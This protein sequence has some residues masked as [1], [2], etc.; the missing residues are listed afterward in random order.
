MFEATP[1][2][3]KCHFCRGEFPEEKWFARVHRA[4][5]CELFCS[6]RCVEYFFDTLG[7]ED[8]SP[9]QERE[10]RRLAAAVKQLESTAEPEEELYHC[11]FGPGELAPAH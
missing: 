8:R 7:S 3:L 4:G 10:S 2:M 5:R 9:E 11:V 1:K 6:P